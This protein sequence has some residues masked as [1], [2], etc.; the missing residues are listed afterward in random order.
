MAQVCGES[1]TAQPDVAVMPTISSD[2][3]A[4]RLSTAR[5]ESVMAFVVFGFR[6]RTFTLGSSQINCL[7]CL[8][9]TVEPV[10]SN[11][12]ARGDPSTT[13]GMNVLHDFF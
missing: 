6:I 1:M 5:T 2:E 11:L 12:L 10:A 3:G 9:D 8:H 13:A 4:L 7:T